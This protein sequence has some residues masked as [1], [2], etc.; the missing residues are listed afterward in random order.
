MFPLFVDVHVIRDPAWAP[1][2]ESPSV[3]SSHSLSRTLALGA[4]ESQELKG[5]VFES[6]VVFESFQIFNSNRLGFQGWRG[7]GPHSCH[8]N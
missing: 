5:H 3:S 7:G 8:S 6:Q 4:K 2:H 1:G